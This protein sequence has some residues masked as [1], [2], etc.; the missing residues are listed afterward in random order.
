MPEENWRYKR[1]RGNHENTIAGNYLYMSGKVSMAEFHAKM[2]ELGVTDDAQ[3]YVTS[4]YWTTPPTDEEV[5]QWEAYD[6]NRRGA[7]QGVAA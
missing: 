7:R 4:V 6:R 3:V 2:A 1:T 5:Q